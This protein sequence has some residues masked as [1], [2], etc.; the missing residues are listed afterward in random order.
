M[1]LRIAVLAVLFVSGAFAASRRI[2]PKRFTIK[3][4]PAHRVVR[5][6]LFWRAYGRH[7]YPH[8]EKKR[9]GTIRYVDEVDPDYKGVPRYVAV[10]PDGGDK[11]EVRRQLMLLFPELTNFSDSKLSWIISRSEHLAELEKDLKRINR[12]LHPDLKLEYPTIYAEL[13]L[14]LRESLAAVYVYRGPSRK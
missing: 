3:P 13:D 4:G 7:Y 6:Q 12:K 8:M 2:D 5:D 14:D 10:I 11:D 9:V 1:T